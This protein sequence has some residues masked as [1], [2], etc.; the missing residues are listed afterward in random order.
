MT[1]LYSLCD[2]PGYGARLSSVQ[3]LAEIEVWRPF[4]GTELLR[5]RRLGFTGQGIGKGRSKYEKSGIA[6]KY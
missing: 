4:L 3:G 6:Y 1:D 2:V 5:L